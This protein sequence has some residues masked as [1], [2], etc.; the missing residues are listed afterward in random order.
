MENVEKNEEKWK[1]KEENEKKIKREK[2]NEG[3]KGEM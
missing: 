2:G 1:V 3:K